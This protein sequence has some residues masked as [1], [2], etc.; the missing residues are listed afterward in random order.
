MINV[1][2][3]I[4]GSSEPYLYRGEDCMD[5]FVEKIN[6]VREDM[7]NRMKEVKE[8]IMTEKDK[9]DFENAKE[10]FICGID[11]KEGDKKVRDHCHFTGAYRGCAHDDCNLGFSMRYDKTPV[12]LHNLQNYDARLIIKLNKISRIDAIAQKS[13]K[14]ITFDFKNLCFK[15]SFSFLSSS[16]DK[17]VKLSKYEDD[18]SVRIGRTISDTVSETP[19]SKLMR[20]WIY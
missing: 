12:F 15:D 8:I 14:F 9:E 16:L 10:R 19:M 18:K 6:K 1:V 7:I 5:K 17:L 2:N 3:A 20:I 4:T 13:E 11:V